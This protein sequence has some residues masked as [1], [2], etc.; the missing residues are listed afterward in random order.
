MNTDVKYTQKASYRINDRIK[1][2]ISST[3][4][5]IR[6]ETGQSLG[7]GKLSRA[8]WVSLAADPKLRK[9]FIDSA[10][11]AILEETAGRYNDKYY[12]VSKKRLKDR[13]GNNRKIKPLY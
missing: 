8:F 5:D 13:R 3:A 9:K 4:K 2:I 11:K 12:Y 7:L 1:S 6:K 10:C